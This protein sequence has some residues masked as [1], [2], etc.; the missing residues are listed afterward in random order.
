MGACV[1]AACILLNRAS[2][3]VRRVWPVNSDL[4]IAADATVDDEGML[5]AMCLEDTGDGA[6]LPPQGLN[7]ASEFG[8]LCEDVAAKSAAA[9]G[10]S[11]PLSE[12]G[13]EAAE[14]W[15]SWATQTASLA[16]ACQQPAA[17]SRDLA[18]VSHHVSHLRLAD[19][20]SRRPRRAAERLD[21]Q[22][23]GGG[24]RWQTRQPPSG[25]GARVAVSSG[26]PLSLFSHSLCR[27][28]SH[29]RTR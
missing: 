3:D 13:L 6:P 5:E 24:W 7:S 9:V 26:P 4:F 23:D 10:L 1:I 29:F 8:A 22:G 27:K 19:K 17:I 25:T 28:L 14:I 2:D 21:R 15:R 18:A 11:W 12:C 16:P 20:C